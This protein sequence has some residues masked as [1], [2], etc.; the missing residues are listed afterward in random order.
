M[1]TFR[2]VND[3][4]EPI[5]DGILFRDGRINGKYTIFVSDFHFNTSNLR[6]KHIRASEIGDLIPSKQF[7]R[8]HPL[9]N[10]DPGSRAYR[11]PNGSVLHEVLHS[12]I[13][14]TIDGFAFA[15]S[16]ET[17][18]LNGHAYTAYVSNGNYI[19]TDLSAWVDMN[20]EQHSRY[21]ASSK[22][23]V[24]QAY[25]SW[26]VVYRLAIDAGANVVVEDWIDYCENWSTNPVY[27]DRGGWAGY[28]R[29]VIPK[30][31]W[32]GF[33][34]S[35]GPEAYNAYRSAVGNYPLRDTPLAR[36]FSAMPRAVPVNERDVLKSLQSF[37]TTFTRQYKREVQP[38]AIQLQEVACLEAVDGARYVRMNQYE[39][40][41]DIGM[42]FAEVPA[43]LNLVSDLAENLAKSK[44]IR[45]FARNQ[46][47]RFKA[48]KVGNQMIDRQ[49]NVLLQSELEKARLA[50]I[51]NSTL[52]SAANTYLAGYYGTRLTMSDLEK[53]SSGISDFIWKYYSEFRHAE[54]LLHRA[55][56]ATVVDSLGA[57]WTVRTNYNLSYN[58]YQGISEFSQVLTDTGWG[59]N[60]HQIW[61]CIPLSFVVDWFYDVTKVLKAFDEE[62]YYRT[63]DINYELRSIEAS[64]DI[65][66]LVTSR[67]G[68]ACSLRYEIYQRNVSSVPTIHPSAID[69][70]GKPQKH[71]VQGAALLLQAK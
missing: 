28:N 14:G 69:L 60:F 44:H 35:P 45:Q 53:F 57:E 22:G 1:I 19:I 25:N 71:F 11:K 8:D 40:W 24:Y 48:F 26:C 68:W 3:I 27:I 52:N 65:T 16:T 54:R 23:Y 29:I 67:Y 56:G 36:Q 42:T 70:Y 41:K 39:F 15:D 17:V 32:D 50:E 21:L 58:P 49:A 33:V 64:T 51:S 6:V 20:V 37:A 7:W 61:E 62:S 38:T 43:V 47:N 30:I 5:C 66:Q 10:Q 4:S 63:L 59:F 46:V 13:N 55:K 9:G 18:T 31:A 2:Y 12:S 34:G